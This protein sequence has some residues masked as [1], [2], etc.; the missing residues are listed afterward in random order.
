MRTQVK[1]SKDYLCLSTTRGVLPRRLQM[2][3]IRQEQGKV[4]AGGRCYARANVLR[5][6][7]Y[8]SSRTVGVGK[9]VEGR[10]K[11]GGRWGCMDMTNVTNGG[12]GIAQGR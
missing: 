7:I 3:K 8:Y 6:N 9:S 4:C 12:R 5:E 1:I 11:E 10:G 2:Y